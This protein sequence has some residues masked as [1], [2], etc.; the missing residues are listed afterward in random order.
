MVYVIS[1]LRRQFQPRRFFPIN[2][3]QIG[4]CVSKQKREFK[5]LIMKRLEHY[6]GDMTLIRFHIKDVDLENR[7]V[8]GDYFEKKEGDIHRKQGVFPLPGI[9]YLQC[10]VEQTKVREIEQFGCKVFNS[11]IFDKW[12][13][14]ELLKGDNNLHYYLP[15]TKKLENETDLQPFLYHYG[16]I[17]LKPI[18]PTH[19]HSSKGIF[20]AKLQNGG[21]E[22]TYRE[23]KDVKRQSFELYNEFQ[24][25][26]LPKLS[27]EYIMQKSIETVTWHGKVTDIRL[28]MNKNAQGDWEVSLLLFRVASNNSHMTQQVVT[29]I[30][31]KSLSNMFPGDQNM[32]EIETVVINLGFQIC[33]SLD[34]SGHHM[35]DLGID[36]GVAEDGHVWIFEINPLPHPLN[37]VQDYSLTRPLEY[38]AYL[39]C[40]N[41]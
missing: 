21:I 41:V 10:H 14:W 23:N 20:R 37:G 11:F 8:K 7:Q 32:E 31:L 24:K 30:P 19:G 29:A 6:P 4:I 26:L 13:C 35:A 39:T 36:L 27:K 15:E 5:R 22:V 34:K 9:I 3:R 38:A 40:K 1:W 17:F 18:D 28:N 2:N 12:E 16:D 33:D 25:W